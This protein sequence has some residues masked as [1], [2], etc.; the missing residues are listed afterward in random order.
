M[1]E[2]IQMKLLYLLAPGALI[3]LAGCVATAP[4]KV[5]MTYDE[6]PAQAAA[7][8]AIPSDPLK[9]ITAQDLA[10][11]AIARTQ[12]PADLWERI[13]RG[14]VMPNLEGDLVRQQEQ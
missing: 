11:Q 8:A 13:R 7:A 12:P 14:Y 10:S 9:P 5:E 4:A 3:A 1:E 6:R 2:R